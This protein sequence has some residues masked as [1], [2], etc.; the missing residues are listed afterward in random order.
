MRR[1]RNTLG[2][3]PAEGSGENGTPGR[4]EETM[5]DANK[6]YRCFCSNRFCRYYGQPIASTTCC[7]NMN[8][9]MNHYPIKP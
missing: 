7:N 2:Q 9:W 8:V 6:T 1:C 3:C 4:G 5:K